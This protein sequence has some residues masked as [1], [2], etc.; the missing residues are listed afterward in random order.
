MDGSYLT[1]PATLEH[2][3]SLWEYPM[4]GSRTWTTG[5]WSGR[6]WAVGGSGK[7]GIRRRQRGWLSVG[8][9][10][11]KF[12]GIKELKQANGG[13]WERGLG[14]Q[15]S[16]NWSPYPKLLRSYSYSGEIKE[17]ESHNS[18]K[19]ICYL[20]FGW[21]LSNT[22]W[23]IPQHL[24]LLHSSSIP[25]KLLSLQVYPRSKVPLMKLDPNTRSLVEAPNV[26]KA[27]CLKD[28]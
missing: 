27:T 8:R 7:C 16:Q 9:A 3:E 25:L 2:F 15:P 24:C 4:K 18:I 11:P 26:E 22:P 20:V 28:L 17:A 13:W 19:L 21:Q 5:G 10:S 12:R 6:L 1:L 14:H 23:H